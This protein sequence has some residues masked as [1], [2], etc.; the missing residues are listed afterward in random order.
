MA[1]LWHKAS[2]CATGLAFAAEAHPSRACGRTPISV[3]C[4]PTPDGADL[5]ELL[6]ELEEK[7]WA[8]QWFVERLR[9]APRRA[10]DAL[11]LDPP[12][13]GARFPSPGG[14]GYCIG[15]RPQKAAKALGTPRNTS[16][17]CDTQY[18]I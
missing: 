1:S 5:A 8:R 2:P 12:D 4:T 16:V 18:R 10:K 11:E 15:W 13:G 14:G 7:E 3:G 17:S 6:I 9:K